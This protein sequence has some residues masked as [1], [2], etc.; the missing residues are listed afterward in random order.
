MCLQSLHIKK[1]RHCGHCEHKRCGAI[2]KQNSQR[3]T[4]DCLKGQMHQKMIIG[5]SMIW[6]IVYLQCLNCYTGKTEGQGAFWIA[7]MK[8]N[9][10]I[11]LRWNI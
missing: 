7:T 4:E 1:Y 11:N 3:Q 2:I 6:F 9:K 8:V 5:N 10:K